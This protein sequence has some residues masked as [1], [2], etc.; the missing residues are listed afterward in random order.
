MSDLVS[1]GQT[2]ILVV[3]RALTPFFGTQKMLAWSQNNQELTEVVVTCS[4]QLC[5]GQV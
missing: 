1:Q 2:Q 3:S 5:L 4:D